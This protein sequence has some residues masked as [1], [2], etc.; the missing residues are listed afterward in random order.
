MRKTAA[1]GGG[2]V[3]A[4]DIGTRDNAIKAAAAMIGPA[5]FGAGKVKPIMNG[6][7]AKPNLVHSI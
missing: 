6:P 7:A 1:G 3:S 5:A 2:V 4:M